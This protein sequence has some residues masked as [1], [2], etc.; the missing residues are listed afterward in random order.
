MSKQI[1]EGYKMTELGD[2]PVEWEIK[3]LEE[4]AEIIMG[5]SP[6]SSSYNEEGQ[7]IPFFQGKTEFGSI[8]PEV[9]KWCTQPTKTAKPLDILMSVRA[10]VG[11]VNINNIESCIGRGLSAIRASKNSNYRY[12]YYFLQQN[13]KQLER[14]SQGSTFTAINSSDLKNLYIIVPPLIEQEK[15]ASILSTIDEHIE[16]VDGLIEKTKELKK[17]LM[18]RLLTKGIGHTEFKMTEIGKIPKVW[19]VK[20]L[21]EISIGKGEY[22][23]NAAAKE[24]E[25]NEPRYLR[26]TDIDD[27]YKLSNQEIKSVDADE[28]EYKKYIL[29]ENDIV[30]ARTGNTTG[31]SYL[32]EKC[33]GELV[34]AGFLIKF[35]I[36]PLLYDSS[37]LKYYVQT[38]YYWDWVQKMS[39]RSGQP[40]INS[41]EYSSLLVPVPPVDEQYKI[42]TILRKVDNRIEKYD[43]KRQKL[44]H[45]KKGLMQKLLTGK[46]KVC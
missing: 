33:D 14:S 46:L 1:R 18:Q 25:Q 7:G 41:K 45:L 3:K 6:D 8:Y 11:D 10:P 13:N 36:N 2:I 22:G 39:L 32:Y 12:I 42:A 31:K 34:F 40:G 27:N 43:I 26:I 35:T 16:Q 29:K 5:Q 30:F 9:K 20:S 24:Y 15:I 37:F 4:I 44:Q 17:G 21:E 38:K 28:D 19:E 23:I